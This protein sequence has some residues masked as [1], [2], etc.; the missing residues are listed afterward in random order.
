[1]T[2]TL[3][4]PEEVESE[5]TVIIS[6]RQMY[7]NDPSFQLNEELNSAAFR[8]HPYHHEVIG[9]LADLNHA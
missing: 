5:R 9:D 6:E 4:T 7:E 2:N 8:V 3:M 1:M